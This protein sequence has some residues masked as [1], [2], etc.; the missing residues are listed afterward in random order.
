MASTIGKVRAVFTASTSGLTSGVNAAASSMKRLRT[1]VAGLSGSMRSLVAIQGA[2]LFGSVVAGATNASRSMLAYGQAEA[3][4]IDS[5]SKVAARLGM[6]YAEMAGLSLAGNLAGVSMDQIAAAATRADVAFIK[7]AGGSKTATAAFQA[8]GLSVENLNGL[9]AAERFDQIAEAIANLPT[10]AERAAAAVAIFGRAGADLLPLFS[11]G[12]GAIAAARAEAERFGLAL[13]NTQGQNV[14]AMNDSFTRAQSAIQ[15]V[16][17]QVVAYLAPAIESVTTAFSDLIGSVGG[18]NIGQAIGDGILQGARFLAEIG[19]VVIQNF[20]GVF[21]YLSNV[22]GQWAAVWDI[23]GRVGSLFAGVGRL[24]S[25]AFLTLVGVF[26]SIGQAILTAVRGAADALGFDT[27]GLD[28]ALSALSGFNQQLSADIAA[29]FN[30]AGENFSAVFA[31]GGAEAGEAIAGPLTRSLDDAIAS[32]QAAASQVDVA[33]KQ[34]VAIKQ[35]T[36]VDVAPIKE[37][38]KGI[39]SSS[40]E[41]IREMFRIMR[42]DTGN[43]VQERQL[44]VLERIAANTEDMGG[45]DLEAVDLAPAAGG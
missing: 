14:E 10:E 34:E 38:V 44:G 27:E 23:A 3:E 37:A 7:A 30:A 8:I 45:F 17:Q 22:G 36:T 31:E 19:D 13:T 32:A 20:S 18:A 28:T 40:A 1:D 21:E 16:I 5:T 42:G 2:Q 29:N 9:S 41:G 25:G 15:G 33:A 26:S 4:V 6:T 12:A 35:T 11:Q 43:D 39:E 24:L